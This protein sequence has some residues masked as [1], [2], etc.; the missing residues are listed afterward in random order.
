MREDKRV[1]RTRLPDGPT[2][3]WSTSA[4]RIVARSIGAFG[5]FAA[6]VS[7]YLNTHRYLQLFYF[8]F[9]TDGPAIC[10]PMVSCGQ[11]MS[12][13]RAHGDEHSADHQIGRPSV[14]KPK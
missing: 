11:L 4:Q 13:A 6:G 2:A 1:V 9:G 14:P 10:Q 3:A 12:T 7:I 5:S 8:G